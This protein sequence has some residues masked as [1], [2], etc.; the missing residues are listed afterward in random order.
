MTR[1]DDRRTRLHDW[2]DGPEDLQAVAISFASLIFYALV[3][4]APLALLYGLWSWLW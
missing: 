4:G 2:R 3:I 1:N